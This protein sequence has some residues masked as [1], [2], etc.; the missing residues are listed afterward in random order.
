ML[1]GVGGGDRPLPD[2]PQL[3]ESFPDEGG[4]LGAR[5]ASVR[6]WPSG[7]YCDQQVVADAWLL[8]RERDLLVAVARVRAGRRH[9]A[10]DARD[11]LYP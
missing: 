4:S 1:A 9:L 2:D 8:G 10:G 11:D 6:M 5:Q 7:R 3:A